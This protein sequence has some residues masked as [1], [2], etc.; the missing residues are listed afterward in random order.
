MRCVRGVPPAHRRRASGLERRLDRARPAPPSPRTIVVDHV[1]GADADAVG[2]RSRAG[3]W[4][5]P[6]C[7]AMRSEV[8]RIV[9]ARSRAAAPGA[10]TTATT[11]A[12]L[13]RQR[14]RRRAS[15]RASAQVEQERR[16]AVA[17]RQRDAPAV[18]VV[19]VEHDACRRRRSRRSIARRS[20]AVARG[21]ARAIVRTGSSAAP[22]AAPSPAR[23]SAARRRRAPRRSRGRPRSSGVASL[24]TM[25]ACAMPPRVFSTATSSLRDAELLARARRR[26]R[27]ARRR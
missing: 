16:A 25:L 27:P 20:T 18:A 9:G 8:A 23:R 15:A 11:R 21:I 24:W 10:A 14:H 3:R 2:Q 17:S 26:A 7:Q 19:V 12:V 5:L 4:R 22:S 6:R 1:V 13:E